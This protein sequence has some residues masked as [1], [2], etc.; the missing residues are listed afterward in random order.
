MEGMEKERDERKTGTRGKN[1]MRKIQREG[2]IKRKDYK[3]VRG[4]GEG[5]RGIQHLVLCNMAD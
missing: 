2:E 3:G 5:Q 1:R 4:G